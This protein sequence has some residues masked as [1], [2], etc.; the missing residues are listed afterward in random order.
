MDEQVVSFGSS[1]RT[2]D[3]QGAKDTG[4][5]LNSLGVIFL[6]CLSHRADI[7]KRIG[8]DRVWG[9]INRGGGSGDNGVR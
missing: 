1:V 2:W 9:V 6:G 5:N 3:T 7:L 4:F 8:L